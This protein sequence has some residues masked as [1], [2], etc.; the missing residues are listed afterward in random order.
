MTE[1][2]KSYRLSIAITEADGKQLEI[3]AKKTYRT[4]SSIAMQIISEHLK[5]V[6][7]E[8]IKNYMRG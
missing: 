6:D 1:P 8:A 3:I 7:M 4:K 2:V 5:T